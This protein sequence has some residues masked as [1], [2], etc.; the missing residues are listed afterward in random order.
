MGYRESRSYNYARHILYEIPTNGR[1]V[2]IYYCKMTDSVLDKKDI[3]QIILEYGEKQ[4]PRNNCVDKCSGP[5]PL[6]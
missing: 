4:E 3:P 2:R 1:P 5:A 6:K